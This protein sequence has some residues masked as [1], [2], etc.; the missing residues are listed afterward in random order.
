MRRVEPYLIPLHADPLADDVLLLI[1]GYTTD[2]RDTARD[3]AREAETIQRLGW[4]GAVYA[5]W[6]DSSSAADPLFQLL[7]PLHWHMVKERA[8]EAGRNLED[9]L[10]PFIS[11]RISFMAF[12]LGAR[13]A[14][15]A[16]LATDSI[17][18]FGDCILLGGAIQSNRRHWLGLISRL[19][20]RLIN[21]YNPLD[22]VLDVLFRLGEWSPDYACGQEPLGLDDPRLLNVDVGTTLLRNG[23]DPHRGYWPALE[24]VL[25]AAPWP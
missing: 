17:F 11:K 23:L 7:P 15:D 24:E 13:V 19:D 14:Y 22:P 20:G 21:C 18:R 8:V 16:L 9:L 6:W 3:F 25:R 10:I 4:R 1:D 2:Q 12:S 5:L